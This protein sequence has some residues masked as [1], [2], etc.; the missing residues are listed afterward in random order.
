[1]PRYASHVP[2][3][4]YARMDS[5]LAFV[6]LADI[7][8]MDIIELVQLEHTI[9]LLLLPTSHFVLHVQVDVTVD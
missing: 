4:I 2:S 3:G 5:T 7:A 1:M 6:L 9:Q 8:K